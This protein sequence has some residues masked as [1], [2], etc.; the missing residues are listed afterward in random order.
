MFNVC[1]NCGMYSV[2]KEIDSA[3]PFAICPYCRYAHPFIQQ[4]LFIVS[5]ASGAGKSTVCLALVS[6]MTECVVLDPDIFWHA[7]YDTPKDNWRSFTDLRLRVAKN[8]GQSGRPVALF[9]S[10]VPEQ[11]ENQPERRYFSEIHYLALVCDDALL[12]QRLQ[13]RP[14]WRQAGSPE[15]IEKMLSFNRWLK[16]NAGTTSPPMSLLDTSNISVAESVELTAEWIREN[17]RYHAISS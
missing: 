16:E 8:I 14:S 4:P 11:F 12:V 6:K 5:G 15:F 1:P 17:L 10:G 7:G 3:G 13:S 2:E 9:T